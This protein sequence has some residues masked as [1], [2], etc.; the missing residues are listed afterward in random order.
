MSNRILH[1]AQQRLR[2]KLKDR[3][4][5]AFLCCTAPA[6]GDAKRFVGHPLANEI[7]TRYEFE[8]VTLS[9]H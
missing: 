6:S 8:D 1:A 7:R 5:L 9:P 3:I 4:S 2:K